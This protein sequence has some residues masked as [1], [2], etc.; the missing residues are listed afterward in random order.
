MDDFEKLIA[1]GMIHIFVMCD[2][3]SKKNECDERFSPGCCNWTG[4]YQMIKQQ[5]DKFN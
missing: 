2:D 5:N 4:Y 3:C 1:T